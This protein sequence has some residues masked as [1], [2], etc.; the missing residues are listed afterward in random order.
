M[1]KSTMSQMIVV[2][3]RTLSVVH[4]RVGVDVQ[5]V[6]RVNLLVFI[7]SSSGGE[8]AAGSEFERVQE[9]VINFAHPFAGS[10]KL[11]TG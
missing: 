7:H 5:A 3:A 10:E 2:R 11:V 8:S 9:N 1:A 6:V 4:P